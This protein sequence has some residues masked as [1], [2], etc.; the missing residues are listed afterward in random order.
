MVQTVDHTKSIFADAEHK[1]QKSLDALRQEFH[2]LHTGRASTALVEGL[3]VDYYG[4]M[5]ALRAMASIATPDA[6]TIQI[7]PWDISALGAIEKA[8]STS[9]L[10]L[11]PHNDGKAIRIQMPDLT[12]ERR[13]ELDK[14]V[15]RIA[16]ENRISIRNVRHDAN[17]QI[18]KLERAGTIGEDV[19]KVAQKKIQDLTDKFIKWVDEAL[20]KKESEIKQ[21]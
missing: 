4:T 12:Q 3:K 9:S 1:M 15:R 19:S 7:Q 13:A 11:V 8:I 17:E 20:A 6:R 10:G 18:K 2:G 16:E 14:L 5:T 21:V